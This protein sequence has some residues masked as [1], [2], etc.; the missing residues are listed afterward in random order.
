MVFTSVPIFIVGSL[1]VDV[2]APAA[3]AIPKL[4]FDVLV[5]ARAAGHWPFKPASKL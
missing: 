5:F 4:Y 2:Y 1:D 3:F